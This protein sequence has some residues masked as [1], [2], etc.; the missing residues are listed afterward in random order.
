MSVI[1]VKE[2]LLNL[3]L[4]GMLTAFEEQ[5]C[6]TDIK[7]LSF[8]E[9]L[10]LLLDRESLEKN[11]RKLKRR[12]AQ[13]KLKI[14][15]SIEEMDYS[16][17]REIDKPFILSLAN[18]T[19]IEKAQN[20]IVTGATGVGKTYLACA[21]AQKACRE[22]F[23]VGYYRISMLLNTLAIAK[24]DGQYQK[25]LNQL[26]NFKLVVLDDFGLSILTESQRRD[27][28]EIF[29]DRY[30][31]KSTIIVSQMPIDSWHEIIGDPT[32]ADAILDRIIHNSYKINMK[33]GSMRKKQN[34]SKVSTFDLKYQK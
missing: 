8:E 13:A 11:N 10:S 24:G 28:L 31:L 19:W 27:L 14:N 23:S 3:K 17:S 4:S 32:I 7:N 5:L 1:T 29:E 30:N 22:G 21:L 9:R 2:Q 15:A 16:G 33:G 6:M 34:S 25:Q 26:S 20:I 18:C 12:L